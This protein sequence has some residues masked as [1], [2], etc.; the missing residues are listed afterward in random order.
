M[1]DDDGRSLIELPLSVGL[2]GTT[3][4]PTWAAMGAVAALVA[5]CSIE[6][7]REPGLDNVED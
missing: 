5:T 4:A 7:K 1:D 2:V 6:V 3:L